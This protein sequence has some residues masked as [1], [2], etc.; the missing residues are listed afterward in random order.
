M[1]LYGYVV[2]IIV[3]MLLALFF[4]GKVKGGELPNPDLLVTFG[5]AQ[6]QTTLNLAY[7]WEKKGEYWFLEAATDYVL[8]KECFSMTYPGYPGYVDRVV[9]KLDKKFYGS[10][11]YVVEGHFY[12]APPGKTFFFLFFGELPAKAHRS[13]A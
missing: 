4:P 7:V 3:L 12:G 10:P 2:T 8:N 9:R 1:R 11:A 13:A 6:E 5:C